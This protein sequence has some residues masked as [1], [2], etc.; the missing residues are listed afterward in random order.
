MVD[1]I[2][3]VAKTVRSVD[4]NTEPLDDD[5]ARITELE[6]ENNQLKLKLDNILSKSVKSVEVNTVSCKNYE[7]EKTELESKCQ[8]LGTV[9]NYKNLKRE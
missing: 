6:T 3:K 1:K 8:T 2:L 9:V 5:K 7:L 4:V